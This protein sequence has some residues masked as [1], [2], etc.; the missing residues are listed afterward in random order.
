[1]GKV[2]LA[3]AI[4]DE[5]VRQAKICVKSQI[6]LGLV[7]LFPERHTALSMPLF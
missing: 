6:L 7:E 2:Q 1:M 3:F 5:S 4:G